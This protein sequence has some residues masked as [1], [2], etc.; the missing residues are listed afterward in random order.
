MDKNVVL[1]GPLFF[2]SKRA[3]LNHKWWK[4][5]LS[6]TPYLN[7]DIENNNTIIIYFNKVVGLECR[8]HNKVLIFPFIEGN[9]KIE[10]RFKE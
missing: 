8:R 10:V 1:E 9:A 2:I 6:W 7:Y 5:N 4:D 3:A